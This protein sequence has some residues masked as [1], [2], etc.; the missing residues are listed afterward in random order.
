M[1]KARKE[2][3]PDGIRA[4]GVA[5]QSTFGSE[6]DERVPIFRGTVVDIVAR[7][8]RVDYRI[9]HPGETQAAL[10]QC[11]SVSCYLPCVLLCFCAHISY[12]NLATAIVVQT[13]RRLFAE[14][15]AVA[16]WHRTAAPN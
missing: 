4:V 14:M 2:Q 3:L 8:G 6:L 11:W 9:W 15:T 13:M 10:R 12:V 16:F 1:H 5:S 7:Q